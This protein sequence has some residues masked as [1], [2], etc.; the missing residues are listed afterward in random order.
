[1]GQIMRTG[2]EEMVRS[3]DMAPRKA[4]IIEVLL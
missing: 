3:Q 2:V 4:L 1:M